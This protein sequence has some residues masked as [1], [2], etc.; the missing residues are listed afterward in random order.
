MV[1]GDIGSVDCGTVDRQ[2]TGRRRV[3]GKVQMEFVPG[4]APTFWTG[5]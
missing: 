1:V 5:P 2:V 4:V 3:N